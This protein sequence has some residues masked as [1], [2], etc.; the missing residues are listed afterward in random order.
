M[1]INDL[2]RIVK[3]KAKK[4]RVKKPK[5]HLDKMREEFRILMRNAS[6]VVAVEVWRVEVDKL[7]TAAAR[8]ANVKQPTIAMWIE[9]ARRASVV[10]PSCDGSGTYYW[11]ACINGKMTHSGP[12]FRCSGKGRQN[13]EDF[14]RNWAYDQHRK[15]Y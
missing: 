9:A 13:Q 1:I 12:C 6:Y 4:I 7:A 10:C 15:A 11:G 14:K 8:K 2:K 5:T 3:S